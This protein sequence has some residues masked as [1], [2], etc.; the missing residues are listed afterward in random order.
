MS[1]TLVRFFDASLAENR[2][3]TPPLGYNISVADQ[4]SLPVPMVYKSFRFWIVTHL[5]IGGKLIAFSDMLDGALA[6]GMT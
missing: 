4:A 1:T 3:F 2:Y 6:L 5:A